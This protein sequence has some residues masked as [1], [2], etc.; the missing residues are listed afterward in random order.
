[1]NRVCGLLLAIAVG[2]SASG[3]VRWTPD[4][5]A[6]LACQAAKAVVQARKVPV[7]PVSPTGICTRCLG[8]GTIGDGASIKIQCPTC[9][10]T[11]KVTK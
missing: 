9:K 1:M 5:T 2:C 11:G 4:L 3:A 10:G 6:D 7:K 8:T